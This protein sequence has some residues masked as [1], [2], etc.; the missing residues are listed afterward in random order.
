MISRVQQLEAVTRVAQRKKIVFRLTH[1][2]NPFCLRRIP[3][4]R[5][6]P[7]GSA[8]QG[9]FLD[10]WSI[11]MCLIRNTYNLL[12]PASW[13]LE[14]G[15]RRSVVFAVWFLVPIRSDTVAN[16]I[17][18]TWA[19]RQGVTSPGEPARATKSDKLLKLIVHK[20]VMYQR[21]LYPRAEKKTVSGISKVWRFERLRWNEGERCGMWLN[22][23]MKGT[24]VMFSHDRKNK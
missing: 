8:N 11:K 13:N 20:D 15:L 14:V 7:G 9:N 17:E 4:H 1:V 3:F 10:F 24:Y 16:S 5:F 2:W 21:N 23:E 18:K 22:T 6:K 19:L 12:G